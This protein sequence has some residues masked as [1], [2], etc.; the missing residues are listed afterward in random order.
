MT[1]KVDI[2]V[3]LLSSDWFFEKWSLLGLDAELNDKRRLQESCRRIVGQ[4]LAN[5][6]K[7]W[8]ADFS[9]ER[10][11]ETSRM[12]FDAVAS[13]SLRDSFASR[14]RELASLDGRRESDRTFNLLLSMITEALIAR[15]PQS[16]PPSVIESVARKWRILVSDELDSLHTLAEG[17]QTPWDAHLRG[18]TPDLPTRLPDWV[19]TTCGQTSDCQKFWNSLADSLSSADRTTLIDWYAAEAREI[20]GE[21]FHPPTWM[22]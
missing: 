21:E 15:R 3:M 5:A 17:S 13:S 11:S 14:V 20:T 10:E 6:K 7:Y 12:F 19:F 18:L 8:S 9:E 2:I 16:V 4:I 22:R 1:P